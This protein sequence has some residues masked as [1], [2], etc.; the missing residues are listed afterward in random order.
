M[1]VIVGVSV[2]AIGS[3]VVKVW[4]SVLGIQFEVMLLPLE[5]RLDFTSDTGF[6]LL[7]D[8]ALLAFRSTKRI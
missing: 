1:A 7:I 5:D 2:I 3:L 6:E 8:D 4:V